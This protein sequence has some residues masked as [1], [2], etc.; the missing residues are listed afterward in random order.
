MRLRVG[1]IVHSKISGEEGRIVRIVT[2]DEQLGFVV[3]IATKPLGKEI[4]APW[5][6]RELREVLHR[7]LRDNS[8][9]SHDKILFRRLEFQR[10]AGVCA[11]NREMQ[12]SSLNPHE[13]GS[14]LIFAN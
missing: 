3:L 7:V 4:E 14:G 5:R 1:D 11:P 13:S 10:F 8:N 2:V 6:P 9:T 12:R